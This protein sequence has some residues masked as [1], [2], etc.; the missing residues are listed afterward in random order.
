MKMIITG[1][2]RIKA[3]K[4]TE[5]LYKLCGF[6]DKNENG[7]IEKPSISNLWLADEG[8]RSE[9]DINGDGK[10]VEAEAKYYLRNLENVSPED[11]QKYP[12]TAEDKRSLQ[13]IFV[14]VY[15]R[16]CK[17][18]DTPVNSQVRST[19]MKDSTKASIDLSGQHMGDK[20]AKALAE[21]LKVNKS[22]TEINIG[23]NQIGDEGA[24]ALADAIKVNRTLTKINLWGNRIGDSGAAALADPILLSNRSIIEINL[25]YNKIGFEG[26]K[27]LSEAEKVRASE[28]DAVRVIL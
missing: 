24:R 20:G 2:S 25:K 21:V 6:N 11:K 1:C 27:A 7:T 14:E 3:S 28:D 16:A 26:A 12:L 10:I 8:Y 23:E 19:L 22:I 18:F 17:K 4:G 9:A 15:E 5:A 13:N